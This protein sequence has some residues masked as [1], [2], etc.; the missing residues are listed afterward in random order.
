[1]ATDPKLERLLASLDALIE[2]RDAY[3]AGVEVPGTKLQELTLRTERAIEAFLD[4]SDPGWRNRPEM[5]VEELREFFADAVAEGRP[6]AEAEWV[7]RAAFFLESIQK[8]LSDED[9]DE[10]GRD[11]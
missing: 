7:A 9:S 8:L 5:S 11:E 2:A 10:P 3:E 4:A 1:M 6:Q